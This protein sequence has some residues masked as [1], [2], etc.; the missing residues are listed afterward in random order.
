MNNP[1]HAKWYA[2]SA[3]QY[4]VTVAERRELATGTWLV[5]LEAPELAVRIKPGQFLMVRGDAGSD[6]LLGRAFAMY[7]VALDSA[8]NPLYVDI[9]FHVIGKMTGLLSRVAPGEPL[10]VWGPLG[11]GFIPE[12]TEHLVMVAGGIGQTPFLAVAKEALGKQTFG[13]EAATAKRVTLCYGARSA[14]FHAGVDEF[15]EAGVDV[16]L[17]TD[18]GSAGHHGLVTDLLDLVIAEAESSDQLRVICCGPEPM[19]C[20]VGALC[21]DRE[22]HCQVSLETPMAC[23]LGICFSCVTRVRQSDGS[24]DFKRTCV[25]GPVFDS[26]QIVW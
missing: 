8:G 12:P 19:M 5:R 22:V 3:S 23:G 15:R 24:W 14:E 25:D 26:K 6:P 20:A 7:D 16:R 10:V 4:S 9:V 17:A 1:L 18:D 11:N 2:D 21:E 13:R